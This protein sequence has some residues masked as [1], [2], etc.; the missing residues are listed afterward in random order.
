ML[1]LVMGIVLAGMIVG[2]ITYQIERSTEI[3][4]PDNTPTP[5]LTPQPDASASPTVGD[6][7]GGSPGPGPSVG[8][9]SN[10]TPDLTVDSY[11]LSKSMVVMNTTQGVIKFK[12]YTDDASQTVHRFVELIQQ[13]FY[14]GLSFHRYVPGFV[15]QGGD[16]SGN[17]TGGS[18]KKLKAEF[19][20]RKHIEGVVA[21]A[22]T[23][24][25]DS[26]DSQFYITLGPQSQLDG[27]YTIFGQVV[28]GMDVVRKLRVG[29]KMTSV[30][31]Q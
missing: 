2:G 12:F 11:G 19:N 4:T 24:D 5:S 10:T 23:S 14:N 17:G 1:F 18:G 22:R 28:E 29:D 25:P 21:M 26:A 3:S 31:I 15:I 9:V 30:F 8:A 7:G 6:S 13:G 27:K 20:S 16:P